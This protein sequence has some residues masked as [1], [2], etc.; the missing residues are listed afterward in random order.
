MGVREMPKSKSWKGCD[1]LQ[2]VFLISR[3][4]AS[5][6]PSKRVKTNDNEWN[7]KK[8]SRIIV[9]PDV[10]S[11]LKSEQYNI[12]LIQRLIAVAYI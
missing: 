5:K 9:R 3:Q 8:A 6:M 7:F 10:R 1:R 12:E 4:T 2:P 11:G